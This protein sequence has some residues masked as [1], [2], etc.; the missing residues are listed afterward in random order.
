MALAT[1]KMESGDKESGRYGKE[2]DLV[3]FQEVLI[4]HNMIE[5]ILHF[6]ISNEI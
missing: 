1:V 6:Y 4:V 5:Q 2:M 3:K